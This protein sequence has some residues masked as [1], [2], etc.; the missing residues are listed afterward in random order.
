MSKYMTSKIKFLFIEKFTNPRKFQPLNIPA[1]RYF[2]KFLYCL[3]AAYYRP[4]LK[5][6]KHS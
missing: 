2:R 1:I 4:T 6:G 3:N 5:I